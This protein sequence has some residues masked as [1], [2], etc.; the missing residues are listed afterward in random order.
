[1]DAGW[2]KATYNQTYYVFR[3]GGEKN[4]GL[5]LISVI[6]WDREMIFA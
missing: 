4:V 6:L 2:L 5:L 1:M 3:S